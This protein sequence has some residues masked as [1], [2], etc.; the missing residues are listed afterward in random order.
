M[1]LNGL[2]QINGNISD[3]AKFQVRIYRRNTKIT[4]PPSSTTFRFCICFRSFHVEAPA[5]TAPSECP[6]LNNSSKPKFK[7][8]KID[9]IQFG[10]EKY[11]EHMRQTKLTIIIEDTFILL[12][13]QMKFLL[14]YLQKF[15]N[16]NAVQKNYRNN[17]AV[18]QTKNIIWNQMPDHFITYRHIW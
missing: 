16:T 13:K 3:G 10:K 7:H 11:A 17:L 15:R 2:L 6:F 1:F 9:E 18:L 14:K 5:K 8:I 12:P 4:F